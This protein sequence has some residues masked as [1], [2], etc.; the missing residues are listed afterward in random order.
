MKLFHKSTSLDAFL[1][2]AVF[3]VGI[4]CD[5]ESLSSANEHDAKYISGVE[6][7]MEK[8][9]ASLNK[10]GLPAALRMLLIYLPI[11]SKELLVA[12]FDSRLKGLQ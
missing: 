7:E 1:K 3:V 6:T 2:S 8:L 9:A 10:S 5:S 12:A 4:L 11:V